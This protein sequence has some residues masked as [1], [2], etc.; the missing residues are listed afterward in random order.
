MKNLKYLI[1]LLVILLIVLIGILVYI[2]LNAENTQT[3]TSII[4]QGEQTETGNQQIG[5]SEVTPEEIKNE[6]SQSLAK[7]IEYKDVNSFLTTTISDE[8]MAKKY[9]SDFTYK[10]LYIPEAAYEQL[11]KEYREKRFGNYDNF[12]SYVNDIAGVIAGETYGRYLIEEGNGYTLYIAAG[13]NTSDTRRY[14]FRETSVMQ[15]V[16]YLD[17]YTLVSEDEQ[18]QYQNMSEAEKVQY[19]LAKFISMVEQKDYLQSYNLLDEDFKNSSFP[20]IND[21][22]D[23]IKNQYYSDN[24]FSRCEKIGEENGFLKYQLILSD[25]AS[26]N[27][28]DEESITKVF[29]IQLSENMNFKLRFDI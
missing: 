25:N 16:T 4:Q 3:D 14:Y 13:Q 8:R 24:Y 9:Y 17:D 20:T 1:I 22:K 18:Q 27:I 15:Y 19:N 10:L 23:Y 7:Q 29:Y 6:V 26:E 21:F 2:S 28:I 11:D 12:L 5:S